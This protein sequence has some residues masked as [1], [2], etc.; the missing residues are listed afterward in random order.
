MKLDALQRDLLGEVFNVGAGNAAAVLAQLLG[1]EIEIELSVPQV[2][3]L[4]VAEISALIQAEDSGTENSDQYCGITLD[5]GG[6]LTGRST[7]VYSQDESLRLV[8]M[9][10]GGIPGEVDKDDFTQLYGDALL[11][12]GN[13][14]LNACL[15]SMANFL[16]LEFEA[17]VPTIRQG[18]CEAIL[19]QDGAESH[20]VL[21]V[22]VDFEIAQEDLH[23]HIALY[24]NMVAME[25]LRGHL[26][27]FLESMPG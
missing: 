14:V 22:Q 3:I 1:G 25:S 4:P 8:Q 16:Q 6:D 24:L 12:V 23:G 17:D 20:D 10:L 9:L 19:T 7:L 15:A 5:H 27:R 26:T 18:S 13:V 2:E 11:E 21:Y